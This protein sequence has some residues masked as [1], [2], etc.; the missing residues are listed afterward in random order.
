MRKPLRLLLQVRGGIVRPRMPAVAA[1]VNV[2]ASRFIARPGA[3]AAP[4][5]AE[6][7][8]AARDF[9]QA[10]STAP[11][12]RR[13]DFASKASTGA[14][15]TVGPKGTAPPLV[16][17][18]RR[19]VTGWCS[20]LTVVALVAV[21]CTYCEPT[22]GSAVCPLPPPGPNCPNDLPASCV[23]PV[24]S[25]QTTV[26]PIFTAYCLTCHSSDGQQSSSPL[27]SYNDVYSNRSDVLAQ[28]YSCRMPPSGQP[29]P[30]TTE[31]QILLQWF[32]CD[33]P[34]N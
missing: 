2:M 24:P 16:A 25:Y 10:R 19:G 30:T 5:P 8:V 21:G 18:S 4:Q 12:H 13:W 26:S 3:A 7:Q 1:A 32:V 29:Q 31:R 34:Q 23:T 27:E 6:A 28:I 33:S 11:A 15:R 14:R 22:P 9:E 20:I 17:A